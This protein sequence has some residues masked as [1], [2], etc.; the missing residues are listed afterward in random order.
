MA[1]TKAQRIGIWVIAAFMAVGTVGSFAIIV[2]ANANQQKDEARVQQLTEQYQKDVAEQDK[3]L[4]DKYY[5]TMDSF[6][7]R[8]TEYDKASI[9]ELSHEDLIVGTGDEISDDSPYAAYYIGW[10]P[11]GKI[12]DST[13]NEKGGLDRPYTVN[14]GEN[15]KGWIEGTRGMKV[16]GVRELSI[17]AELA[18]GEQGA[19][20]RVAPNTPI[21]FIVFVVPIPEPVEVPQELINYYEKGRLQ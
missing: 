9:T 5:P 2:L 21:K 18:Y 4:S 16:G 8:V 7:S 17:P 14:P 15:I 20:D 12:F 1:A 19:G 11:D 10:G 13:F 3:K 6:R